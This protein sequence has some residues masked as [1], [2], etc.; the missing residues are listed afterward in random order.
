M[1]STAVSSDTLS[2][3]LPQ[4]M[5]CAPQELL[6]IAPPTLPR[7]LVLGSGAKIMPVVASFWLSSSR[8]MPGWTR[9]HPS[10]A[11]TSSR[12]RMYLEKSMTTA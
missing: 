7:L 2:T 12:S 1:D 8:M 10:S 3:V 9:A 4:T 11:L 6:P 5:E